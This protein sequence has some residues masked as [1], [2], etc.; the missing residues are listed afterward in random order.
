MLALCHRKG[1]SLALIQPVTAFAVPTLGT[2]AA[3]N[4][5]LNEQRVVCSVPFPLQ[6]A[7]LAAALW[8]NER[9]S[10]GSTGTAT[11]MLGGMGLWFP[12]FVNCGVKNV[13]ASLGMLSDSVQLCGGVQLCPWGTI[14]PS[15]VASENTTGFVMSL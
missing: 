12:G 1:S 11:S 6:V 3:W 2:F 9:G 15:L 14:H 13:N 5:L 8:G 10:A 4:S 7:A